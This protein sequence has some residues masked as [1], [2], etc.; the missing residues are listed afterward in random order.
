MPS[1]ELFEEQSPAYKQSVFP[2]GIPVLSVEVMSTM[3][4]ERYAHGSL[5]MKTFGASAP[6]K[7]GCDELAS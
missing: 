3:G 1:W 5:G 2:A 6:A 4:W 7:V